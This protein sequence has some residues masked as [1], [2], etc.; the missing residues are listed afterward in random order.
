L[1]PQQGCQGVAKGAR[2]VE[3]RVDSGCVESLD[4]WN[5]EKQSNGSGFEKKTAIVDRK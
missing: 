1:I 3:R 5:D 2:E 4:L